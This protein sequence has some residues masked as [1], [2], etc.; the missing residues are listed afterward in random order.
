MDFK[1]KTVYPGAVKMEGTK[2]ELEGRKI[3]NLPS[4]IVMMNY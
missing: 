4:P 3:Y 1:M 2:R